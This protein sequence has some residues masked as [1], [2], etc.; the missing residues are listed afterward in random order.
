MGT[1][2][3]RAKGKKSRNWMMAVSI[4][5]RQVCKSTHTCNKRL[6]GQLLARWE[7]EVFEGRFHLPKSNPP[8]FEIWANE[9][10]DKVGHPNTRRRYKSSVGKL[11]DRFNG[12]RLSDVSPQRIE[13]YKAARLAEGVEPATINHDLRVL[14]RM[15]RLAE[16]NQLI[17]RNPF[18]QVDFLRQQPPR[19]PHIV[20]FEEEER[21]LTVAVPYIRVLVVLILE[22][23]MRSH[24]E[25]LSLRWDAVDFT[26]D[27]IRVQESKTRAGIRNVPLSVRCKTELLRWRKMVGPEF[28]PFVFP[29]LRKPSQS[30][31]DI[32]HAWAK[33]LSNAGLEFFVTYNLRHSCASRLSAAGVSDLFV[34]Q[35]IGHSSPGILQ[36]YSKAI[37]EYKRDAVRKL[38][39]LRTTHAFP[40][41]PIATGIPRHSIN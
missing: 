10:L 32:R 25:A 30:M 11:K 27:C 35:M 31:K 4:N 5:G 17:A 40:G 24:K 15:M 38:E 36:K 3:K 6:A 12:V 28:S 34:A 9:F 41:P 13:E 2:Y 16:R 19:A 26:N 39:N 23:G 21:I 37:D 1:L 14:R 29:N 20:T 33:T 22:T 7:T 18:S 8:Y